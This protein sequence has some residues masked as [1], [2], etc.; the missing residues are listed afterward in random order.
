[1]SFDHPQVG[2][3]WPPERTSV[4]SCFG[5]LVTCYCEGNY[6]SDIVIFSSLYSLGSFKFQV[7]KYQF[8]VA[9]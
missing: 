1:M 9:L 2:D 5:T 6:D 8:L 3:P 4:V 7:K